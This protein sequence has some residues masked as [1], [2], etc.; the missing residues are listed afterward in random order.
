[1]LSN[2]QANQKQQSSLPFQIMKLSIFRESFFSEESRPSINTLRKWCQTGVFNTKT[3]GDMLYIVLD[4][5]VFGVDGEEEPK[6]Q[7]QQ[8]QEHDTATLAS[9]SILRKQMAS[10]DCPQ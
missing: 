7:E 1:M 4:H 2:T 6:T 10:Q 5:K 8:Y 3:L 9:L